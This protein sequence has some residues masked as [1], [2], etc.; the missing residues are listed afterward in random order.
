[1]CEKLENFVNSGSNLDLNSNEKSEE[2]PTILV[3]LTKRLDYRIDMAKQYAV[4]CGQADQVRKLCFL[5]VFVGLFVCLPVC[6]FTCLSVYL[7]VCRQDIVKK[8]CAD[9]H[10]SLWKAWP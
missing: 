10:E 5:P 2:L 8:Y 9:F 4:F 1:M 7:F 3:D 6:L